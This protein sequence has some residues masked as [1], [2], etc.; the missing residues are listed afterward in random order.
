MTDKAIDV[1]APAEVADARQAVLH[2]LRA[3]A[4][5][6]RRTTCRRSGSAKYKGRFDQGWDAL[7]EETF[8]RQKAARRDPGRRRAHRPARGDPGVGR[9]ARR[10]QA[11]ARP[12]DGGLRR[13]P[14]AH[15]P[16]RR[17]ADRRARGARRS[18]TTRSSTTSSA[19]TAR[20]AE[21]TLNGTFN[22]LIILNGAAALETAE[23]MAS[24]IDEFG[25]PRGV[26]PLRGRL[27][28]RDG[29]AVPV[30]QAG[31]LALGRHPQ[32]HDRA[33]AE[34]LHG[35][36]ARSAPSSTTS[37]TSRRPSSKPPGLPEPT[38]VNGVQQMPHPR[39]EHDATR[40]TTPSAAERHETQY[41]EMFVQPRHLPPG[42]D[43]GHP[44]QHA[45]GVGAGLPAVRR[46]RLGA[47]RHHD[48]L[49]ARPT[50]SPPRTP[51]S[52]PS[53]SACSSSRRRKYN[54]LPLDDRRVER[55]NSDIAGR[56]QLVKGN[57]QLLFGGMGRL[58][59]ELGDQHQE[60]VAR[61]HRRDRRARRR[62]RRRD[63]RPGRRVRRLEPLRS[64][65]ASRSTA[66]TC[67]ALQRFNVEGDDAAARR[68]P[69]G[70]HGVRLRRR[71]PRQ[72]RRPSPSTST[73]TR[74]ARAASRRTVPMVFSADE[75]TDVGADT[76]TARQRRLHA[77]RQRRSPARST[78]CRSTS[79]R[80]PR[81]STTSSRPRNASRSRWPANR[82]DRRG[83]R[84][85]TARS[86]RTRPARGVA[87]TSC[88]CSPSS[89][90]LRSS[91]FARPTRAATAERWS[92]SH[93]RSTASHGAT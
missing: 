90:A 45:V 87:P 91:P 18:S 11:G 10:P 76:G 81:T 32:R 17:P 59:R 42:L 54:V 13:V 33:L 46:R 48:R 43:R 84:A 67:S 30:D 55:F 64:R 51:T 8:A 92:S 78:G 34:R 79:T 24:R 49:D 72:G 75:T 86:E 7:R 65:T 6:T 20:R 47:L 26:Q 69:P 70:A 31:R 25:T 89:S 68:R 41:F 12:P 38:F 56:P 23:F 4:R 37:S 36:R 9:H 74:S 3:R 61:G 16:P 88:S 63:H 1:G 29:H 58:T 53:C 35:A 93:P 57:S 77:R 21:G 80:T 71:R 52:S 28:A 40:S 83:R 60:Q 44:A 62:R 82:D 73:A 85:L 50:T 39:R 22:E 14:G 15:R 5:R 66:T 2:V 19:T 27:G